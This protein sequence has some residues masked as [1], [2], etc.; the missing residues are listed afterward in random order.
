MTAPRDQIRT[1][2]NA[3]TLPAA[4]GAVDLAEG[5]RLHLVATPGLATF[6]AVLT[7]A[8]VDEKALVVPEATLAAL[9]TRPGEPLIV[10]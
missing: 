8:R 9:G 4:A 7:P 1:V 6:R 2:R 3:R 5:E 10:S